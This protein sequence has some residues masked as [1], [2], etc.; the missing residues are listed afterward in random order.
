[1]SL[2]DTYTLGVKLT[3]D[4]TALRQELQQGTA[5]LNQFAA[6]SATAMDRA[7]KGIDRAAAAI[8][9]SASRAGTSQQRSAQQQTQSLKY[10]QS[11]Y[12]EYMQRA[13]EAN[14]AVAESAEESSSETS[15]SM[16]DIK[17][18]LAQLVG[19]AGFAALAKQ[20]WDVGIAFHEFTQNMTVALTT[21]LGSEGA[22]KSFL[23]DILEFAKQTPYA[24]TDLTTQAQNLLS[25]G[26]QAQQVIPILTAIGD[27]ATAM[28]TGAE[29][30]SQLNRAIGQIQAKGRLQGDELLQLSEGGINGLTILAN[31]ANMS[32][33]E[34]QKLIS[35]GLVPADQA[36]KGLID[37]IENGTDGINGQTAAFDGLMEKVKASGGITATLDSTNTAFRNMSAAITAELVPAYTGF[38]RLAIQGMGVVQKTANAFNGLSAPVQ[39]AAL[40]FAAATVAVRLLNVQGRATAVWASF[41][42]AMAANRIQMR[43]LAME[44]GTTRARLGQM[45]AVLGGMGAAARSAGSALLGAF[46]GPVGL[47]ITAA[48][49]GLAAFAA[50]QAQAKADIE[51]VGQTLDEQTGKVTESTREWT[52]AKLAAKGGFFSDNKDST[53]DAAE[54]LGLDLETVTDAAMGSVEAL[55][56]VKKYTDLNTPGSSSRSARFKLADQLGIDEF[57]VATS[58]DVLRRGVAGSNKTIEEAIRVGVQKQDADGKTAASID[59][60]TAAYTKSSNATKQWTDEQLKSIQSVSDAAVKAFTSSLGVSGDL[61]LSTDKDVVEA[62]D[63]VADATR[64]IRD[65]EADLAETRAKKKVTA[66]DIARGE[67][68]VTEARKRAS[69]AAEKLKDTEDRRDPVAQYRKQLEANLKAA[70]NF[71]KN[72]EKLGKSGLNATDLL[73][74]INQGP[75]GS[76]DKVAALLKD[77]SLIKETN[78]ARTTGDALADQVGDLATLAQQALMT[79]GGDMGDTLALAFKASALEGTKDTVSAIAKKLGEDPQVLYDTGMTM[80]LSFLAGLSDAGKYEKT[81]RI[82]ADGSFQFGNSK[83]RAYADGGIY[84]GY[85]PGRDTGL[86]AVGGGEAIMRPEWTRAMGADYVHRMNAIA[87]SSGAS[88]V[89]AE[90]RR[91]LGGFASGGIAPTVVKVPV[92]QTI[93][94]NTPWTINKAYFT[95]PT[96]AARWGD[97]QRSRANTAGRRL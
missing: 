70:K 49:A 8:E 59:G 17:S 84:P 29:G 75:A 24:F 52:K 3:G 44:V 54:K 33:I 76:K 85:T 43:L 82:N 9:S 39:T 62:R 81:V 72:V 60:V 56:K 46:G 57:E 41:Q 51:A 58:L 13:V 78:S 40:A 73:D 88:G 50:S 83:T 94:R 71:T 34:F 95:D 16:D 80:G 28:G 77:K 64:G 42:G 89:Q 32:T 69:E 61:N 1:M 21:M 5:L 79:P 93:E 2:T 48:V 18:T 86:I 74:I 14:K 65:A 53:F 15:S 4:I 91:Y 7:S 12:A 20:V 90:M 87:R 31:Q 96:A 30:M 36:I 37:G 38:L 55:K 35:K 22:A 6:A 47:A 92:S 68:A 45:R 23:S 97:G 10:T 19:A 63:D 67:D 11:A 25:F 27:A 26:L 66:N